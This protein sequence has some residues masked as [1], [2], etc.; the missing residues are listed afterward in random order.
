MVDIT[1]TR[2]DLI[3]RAAT[4]LGALPSGETLSD[5]DR[6]TIDNLVD[7]FLLQLSLDEVADVADSDAIPS[8]W[9]LPLA[10]L[11]ANI[12]APSFGQQYSE[13][14]KLTLERQL[15]RITATKRTGQRQ[16]AEYF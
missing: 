16:Q 9:F 10:G 2:V 13:D 1:K 11:L 4:E 6:A 12:A 5:D 7:P 15:R 3:E 8:E 14:K